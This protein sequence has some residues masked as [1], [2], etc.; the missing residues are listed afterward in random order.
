VYFFCLKILF[1][2]KDP[3]LFKDTFF[4]T[5]LNVFKHPFSLKLFL[6]PSARDVEKPF[7]SSFFFGALPSVPN[8]DLYDL[9]LDPWQYSLDRKKIV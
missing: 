8:L 5:V 2:F 9:N 4:F 7:L 3:F 1:L 6:Y